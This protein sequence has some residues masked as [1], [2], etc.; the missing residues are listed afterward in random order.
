MSDRDWVGDHDALMA[1]GERRIER[2]HLYFN[3]KTGIFG[4]MTPMFGEAD[5]DKAM[6]AVRDMLVQCKAA[7]IDPLSV[8]TEHEGNRTN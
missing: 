6:A 3:C 4:A 8:F 7:G 5:A 1:N 2:I